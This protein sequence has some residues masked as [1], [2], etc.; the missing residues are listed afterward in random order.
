[1]D[2]GV[3]YPLLWSKNIKRRKGRQENQSKTQNPRK[4]KA[5][6]G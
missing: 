6:K 4:Q 3:L 2:S 1:M 5:K